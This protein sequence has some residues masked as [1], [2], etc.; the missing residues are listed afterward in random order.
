MIDLLG[1]PNSYFKRRLSS[2]HVPASIFNNLGTLDRTIKQVLDVD[3]PR[4]SA[5]CSC[6]SL[7]T[8]MS[9][10]HSLADNASYIV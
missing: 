6:S 2:T 10:L 4:Y 8:L 7:L 1:L 3:L 5:S 9:L